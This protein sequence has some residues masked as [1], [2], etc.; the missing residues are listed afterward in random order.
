M[1]GV[2]LPRMLSCPQSGPTELHPETAGNPFSCSFSLASSIVKAY[3]AHFQGEKL[4]GQ[5]G[6][7]VVK[8]KHCFSRLGFLW[9]RSWVPTWYRSSSHA[10]AVSHIAEV[11]GPTTRIYIYVLGGIGEKKEKK[12]KEEKEKQEIEKKKKKIGNRC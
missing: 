11:E 1:A 4:G 7:G 10:E 6:D 8:F 12:E 3:D 9:F 5:A 2:E